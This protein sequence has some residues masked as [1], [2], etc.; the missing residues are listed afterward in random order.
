MRGIGSLKAPFGNCRRD[1][2]YVTSLRNRFLK[3]HF[4]LFTYITFIYGFKLKISENK[5]KHDGYAPDKS[6]CV[7]Q[8]VVDDLTDLA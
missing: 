4:T 8:L 1:C 2:E 3:R 5:A 6:C 7:K